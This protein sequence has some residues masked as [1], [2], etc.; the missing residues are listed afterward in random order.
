VNSDLGPTP[1]PATV[2]SGDFLSELA[3]TTSPPRDP[4]DPPPP[5]AASVAGGWGIAGSGRVHSV[6]S[7]GWV[8]GGVK[9]MVALSVWPFAEAVVFSGGGALRGAATDLL[10]LGA[11]GLVELWGA[12]TCRGDDPR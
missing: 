11:R 1:T 10:P 7:S 5:S 4:A 9:E 12:S 8:A 3:R 6:G 2:R